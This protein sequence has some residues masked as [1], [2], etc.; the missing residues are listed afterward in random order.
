[1][2][3]KWINDISFVGNNPY[4]G[5]PLGDKFLSY[6]RFH[7]NLIV[8]PYREF[9]KLFWKANCIAKERNLLKKE[10]RKALFDEVMAPLME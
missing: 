1:M 2:R 3:D 4:K 5:H 9:H 10:D 7:Y 8:T 6:R